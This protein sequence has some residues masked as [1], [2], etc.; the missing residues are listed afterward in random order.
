[1]KLLQL[2]PSYYY[3]FFN[4]GNNKE[5]IF[6]EEDNY[7]YFLNLLKKY[8]I[9]IADFYSYCLLPNHFHLVFRIKDHWDLPVK[10]KIGKT[11]LH[12]PFS[13]LF[14][15]YTKAI[16]KRYNRSGSLFQKHP[17]RIKIESMA[18][19]QN[20]IIYVNTNPSH[21]DI[22][23]FSNYRFSSYNGLISNNETLLKRKETIALFDDVENFKFVCKKQKIKWELIKESEIEGL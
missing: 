5:N 18:Y 6:M 10:I 22:S 8:L 7:F 23:D 1:M 3:H 13:N 16:N 21:H 20:L 19:F 9:P 4:R 14:N 15:A 11:S 2:E 12:Q 17:K